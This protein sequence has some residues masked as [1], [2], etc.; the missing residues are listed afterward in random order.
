[1]KCRDVV[2][3]TAPVPPSCRWGFGAHKANM[4]AKTHG[5]KAAKASLRSK[6][7][8][9]KAT[10]QLLLA[11]I[12]LLALCVLLWPVHASAEDQNRDSDVK[13]RASA[14]HLARFGL[15]GPESSPV[16]ATLLADVFISVKT[17]R[18]F[19]STRLEPV[20]G[21]WFQLAREQTWFF[22][23]GEDE[24][25]SRKTGENKRL[26]RLLVVLTFSWAAQVRVLSCRTFWCMSNL[27][28][29]YFGINVEARAA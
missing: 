20:L 15:L 9:W 22:T 6:S 24:E 17:S 3:M 2:A 23:D 11:F 8:V 18:K 7:K 1:M 19:H 14:S 27:L 21:T 5:R 28:S 16:P 10:C 13:R 4:D 25:L 29:I 26:D 12:V